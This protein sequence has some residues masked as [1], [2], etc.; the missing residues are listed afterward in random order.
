MSVITG[1]AFFGHL[2]VIFDENSSNLTTSLAFSSK[3]T[4]AAKYKLLWYNKCLRKMKL[5]AK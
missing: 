4:M 5:G 2:I 1:N 3:L